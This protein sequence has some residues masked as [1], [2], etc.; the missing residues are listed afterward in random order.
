[1]DLTANFEQKTLAGS[2][3]FRCFVPKST[4]FPSEP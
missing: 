1:L 3:E 2:V 4:L